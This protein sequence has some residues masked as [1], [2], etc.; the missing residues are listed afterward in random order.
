MENPEGFHI[1]DDLA[2]EPLGEL[3]WH[4]ASIPWSRP[5]VDWSRFD[6]VVIRSTW[7]YQD[8]PESFLATLEAIEQTGTRLLNPTSICRWNMHKSYLKWLGDRD[9]TIVPTVWLDGLREESQVDLQHWKGGEIVVKPV[10]G[11]NAD[12]T[13]R[14][15]A[16]TGEAWRRACDVFANRPL[17]VQPFLH[18]IVERGEYS[19]IYFAGTF[20]HAILKTPCQGD[21]RVQE[22]HGGQ[23]SSVDPGPLVREAAQKA[24][25]AIEETLLYARVDIAALDDGAYAVTELE[26]IE[27]SLYFPYGDESA[28]AFATALDF[29]MD[30]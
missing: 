7:D 6:A 9:V 23:I 22:E 17:M 21:F 4:V 20:S 30:L 24:I 3:G 8:S 15:N 26:L 10:V 11:A 29:M 16:R 28:Q 12:D 19:L 18:S 25:D 27:P 1:Y 5:E 13:Y 2:V 14:L